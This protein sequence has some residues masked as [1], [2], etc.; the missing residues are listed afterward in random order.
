MMLSESGELDTIVRHP[1]AWWGVFWLPAFYVSALIVLG[2]VGS[3]WT[4]VQAFARKAA[5]PS[6]ASGRTDRGHIG[7]TACLRH[8]VA[9]ARRNT[10][11]VL[12]DSSC[13]RVFPPSPA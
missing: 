8:H 1:D 12:G 2:S 4:D 9:K 6:F 13:I 11:A 5:P 7:A 3:V 10:N